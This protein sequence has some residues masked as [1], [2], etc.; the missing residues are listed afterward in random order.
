[1]VVNQ[2]K[3]VFVSEGIGGGEGGRKVKVQRHAQTWQTQLRE[4]SRIC[5]VYW[6]C[7]SITFASRIGEELFKVFHQFV[8]GHFATFFDDETPDSVQR[9]LGGRRHFDNTNKATLTHRHHHF[10]SIFF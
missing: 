9:K 10:S 2:N 8:I 4:S 3:K 7:V 1:M 6:E 5:L